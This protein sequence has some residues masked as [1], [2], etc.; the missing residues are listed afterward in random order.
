MEQTVEECEFWNNEYY[1]ICNDGALNS[2]KQRVMWP[3]EIFLDDKSA[4]IMGKWLGV[5]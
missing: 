5:N 1:V 3:L 2:F 4:S